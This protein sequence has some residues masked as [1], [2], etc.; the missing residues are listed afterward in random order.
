MI[1]VGELLQGRYRI[2]QEIG[3]GGIGVIFL[4]EDRNMGKLVVVKKIK[5]NFVERL[6][7]RGEVDILKRL[8][9]TYLPQVHDFFQSG[10]EVYT[11]M[12]YIEGCDMQQY[13]M[14]GTEVSEEQICRWLSQLL[15]VLDYLH[16]QTPPIYHCDIKPANIMITPEGNVCLIDFNISLGDDEKTLKGLSKWYSAPEQ[17]EAALH[18]GTKTGLDGRM[19]LYSLGAS[20]YALMTGYYPDPDQESVW[21]Q[22]SRKKYSSALISIL[23]KSME[24]KPQRRFASAAQMKKALEKKE[25]WDAEERK[26][27]FARLGVYTVAVLLLTCGIS[28]AV[29]GRYRTEKESWQQAQQEF[30][31]LCEW[32]DEAEITDAALQ[33][34]NDR[35]MTRYMADA[36]RGNLLWQI[37]DAYYLE[38]EYAAAAEYYQEAEEYVKN[39]AGIHM[40]HAMALIKDQ[41]ISE[42]ERYLR[43]L[44]TSGMENDE[45]K[46]LQGELL[47]E[48]KDYEGALQAGKEL[49][50]EST[51]R[52]VGQKA[53]I[54]AADACIALEEPEK[55]LSWLKK[56]ENRQSDRNIL[57]RI[58]TVALELSGNQPEYQQTA[59]AYAEKICENWPMSRTDRLNLAAVKIS[60]GQEEEAKELLLEMYREGTDL[61]QVPMYL[62][63]LVYNRE[64]S[65]RTPSEDSVSQFLE[66]GD[67]AASLY[68]GEKGQVRDD[69]MEDLMDTC[70]RIRKRRDS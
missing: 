33:L 2:L 45:L 27:W 26:V 37:A 46:L 8:R 44:E 19:D 6:E 22:E 35:S 42:A 16:S 68:E 57:R 28:M 55:G 11:V 23:S 7:T 14:E 52:E 64:I 24:Q 39:D 50:A 32:G 70:A 69:K 58:M 62:A 30:Y 18:P 40:D 43:Q 21:T 65:G 29:Y 61:Y 63:I 12:D 54:L 10:S 67:Q 1:R 56:G 9:H 51:S 5:E 34:L 20:F 36:E 48:K 59:L 15:E 38:E 4:A 31:R 13:L 66:Y 41:R 53:C 3:T 60:A 49:A 47:L 25:K 17:R